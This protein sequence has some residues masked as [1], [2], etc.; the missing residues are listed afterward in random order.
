M[1]ESSLHTA[2][3][4]AR[5]NILH[6][7]FRQPGFEP[8]SS[9]PAACQ[10]HASSQDVLADFRPFFLAGTADGMP[11]A[12]KSILAEHAGSLPRARKSPGSLKNPSYSRLPAGCRQATISW[13][14]LY[15]DVVVA[16]T[17]QTTP[18]KQAF[19]DSSLKFFKT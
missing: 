8:A 10:Q 3:I 13:P 6:T 1:G 12:G 14:N 11:T 19:D 4:W 5:K 2:R 17:P 15:C 18:N 16:N 9:L 7:A